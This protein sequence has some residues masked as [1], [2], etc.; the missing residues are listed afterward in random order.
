MEKEKNLDKYFKVNIN[1]ID[2]F[3]H[4]LKTDYTFLSFKIIFFSKIFKF[5]GYSFKFF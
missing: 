4:F 1:N 5:K 3:L 2:Y